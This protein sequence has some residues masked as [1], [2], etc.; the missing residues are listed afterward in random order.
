VNITLRPWTLL[1]I[2]F[3]IGCSAG[4]GSGAAAPSSDDAGGGNGNP[5]SNGGDDSHV[6]GSSLDAGVDQGSVSPP[7]SGRPGAPPMP[8]PTLSATGLF[9][10]IAANGT[11]VLGDGVQEYQPKYT[12]WSDGAAKTRWVRLPP[13][14]KIDSTDPNHWSFPVGTK[15]WKEFAV[16]GKRLETRLVWRFG[17]GPDDFLYVAYGWYGDAGAPSD[18][19]LVDPNNG[20]Q[21]VGGTDHDI[22]TQQDCLACHNPLREHVLGFGA[23]QLAHTLPGL[24]IQSLIQAGALTTNPNLA[25]LVVPGDATAQAALGYLHANCG[26][27]HNN[28]PGATGVP[29]PP[30]LMRLAIGAKTVQDTDIYK[31]TV[32]VLTTDFTLIKYRIAGGDIMSSCVSYGMALR[33]DRGQM[34]PL[35]TKHPDPTGIAAV[36]AWIATLPKPP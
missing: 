28:A 33:G 7:D 13:G 17:P 11:L 19:D 2:A 16:N 29:D 9:K 14:S 18:A 12:L 26:N 24:T 35:A 5:D 30:M 20:A 10:S 1:A 32:N 25:D 23:M 15:F 21:N 31:S 4:P 22:P 36:N 27:C 8:P 6:P 34:P 3:F